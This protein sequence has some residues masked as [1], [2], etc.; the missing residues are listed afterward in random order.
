MGCVHMYWLS[1]SAAGA[2]LFF[3]VMFLHNTHFYFTRG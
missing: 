2:L 3:S 1:P